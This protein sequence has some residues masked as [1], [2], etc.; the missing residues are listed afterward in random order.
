MFAGVVVSAHIAAYHK[1]LVNL[2]LA[3]SK[4]PYFVDPMTPYFARNF[5]KILKEKKI[6]RSYAKLA[7]E[8]GKHVEDIVANQQRALAIGDFNKTELL[9]EF[10][11]SVLS[12]QR[13][14]TPKIKQSSLEEILALADIKKEFKEREPLFLVPPYFFAA[15]YGD[16]WYRLSLKLAECSKKFKMTL[17]IYPV[18]CISKEMLL[19]GSIIKIVDD[20]KSF[21]GVMLWVADFD[22]FKD[23]KEYLEGYVNLAVQFTKI[24]TS[25]YSFYGGYFTAVLSKE[26]LVGYSSGVCHSESKNID[27]LPPSAMK[28]LMRYYM[29]FIRNKAQLEYATKFLSEHPDM[30]CN[31]DICQGIRKGLSKK[32]A[33]EK[34]SQVLREDSYYLKKHYLSARWEELLFISASP[35]ATIIK[36]LLSDLQ[37]QEKYNAGE[38]LKVD[39]SYIKRW[40]EVLTKLQE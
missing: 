20:Y 1:S 14:L 6:K 34:Y 38:L 8:Y 27:T 33:I 2:F 31:C 3:E 28:K 9:E 22:E 4:I 23:E 26:T 39:L 25:A 15:K 35:I 40:S 29:P 19:D 36:R 32:D 10:A 37:L 11:E 17:G 16:E 30:M 12:F 24:G 5:N 7:K 18:I 13:N 21:D